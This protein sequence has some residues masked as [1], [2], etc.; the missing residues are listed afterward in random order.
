MEQFLRIFGNYPLLLMSGL[1]GGLLIIC[2]T[3]IAIVV[4]VEHYH[5]KSAES[6]Q[7]HQME[8]LS[9]KYINSNVHDSLKEKTEELIVEDS[10]N[11]LKKAFKTERPSIHVFK[12]ILEYLKGFSN[13]NKY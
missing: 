8:M 12:S 13:K 5:I 9:S 6:T 1:I 11:K 7:K 3:I 4:I 10:E 2:I